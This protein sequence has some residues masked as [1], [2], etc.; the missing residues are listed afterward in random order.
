MTLSWWPCHK[1]VS[2]TFTFYIYIRTYNLIFL[3]KSW[4]ESWQDLAKKIFW[5]D[6]AKI[7]GKILARVFL[8]KILLRILA[9][10]CQDFILPRSSQ[11]SCQDL[12]KIFPRFY[13]GKI[14][15]RILPRS[16][17]DLTKILQKIEIGTILARPHEIFARSC[18][19]QNFFF[20]RVIITLTIL[21]SVWHISRKSHQR[22]LRYSHFP[23][24]SE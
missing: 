9:R 12:G 23:Q 1:I 15:P 8:G 14:L 3:T 21:D 6:L 13:L 22:I 17:Q 7:L 11:E 16:W 24:D 19:C 5:Q 20:V 10:S 4:Q 2:V 18:K